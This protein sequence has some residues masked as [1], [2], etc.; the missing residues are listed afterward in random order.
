MTLDFYKENPCQCYV[1]GCVNGSRRRGLC[2][3]HYP[4]VR[5][6]PDL[7]NSLPEPGR[8]WCR[9]RD[10]PL[11]CH[12]WLPVCVVHGDQMTALRGRYPAL[13]DSMSYLAE[14]AASWTRG[15]TAPE[16]DPPKQ[17]RPARHTGPLSPPLHTRSSPCRMTGCDHDACVRGLCHAHYA[18][19]RYHQLLGTYALPSKRPRCRPNATAG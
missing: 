18:W 1:T 8:I 19:A 12:L 5:R 17:P 11:S 6:T 15:A 13:T 10:C 7:W 14:W 2:W 3:Q 4:Q 16:V 9:I